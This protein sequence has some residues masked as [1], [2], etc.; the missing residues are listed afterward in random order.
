MDKIP[1]SIYD[2]FGYL[3]PGAL[4]L[5]SIDYFLL[6]QQLIK[7]AA[8]NLI[9]GF[10]SLILVYI[11]GHIISSVSCWCFEKIFVKKFLKPPSVT[12]FKDKRSIVKLKKL[13]STYY[14]P[15]S[16]N[17]QDN[18]IKKLGIESETSEDEKYNAMFQ[19]AFSR[20][21]IHEPS[22]L[23]LNNFLY[24]Y[25]FARSVSL[26]CLVMVLILFVSSVFYKISICPWWIVGFIFAF[27]M[28]FFRYLKF[29][30][31]YDRD[32]FLSYLSLPEKEAGK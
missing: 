26:V 11:I 5:I 18:I 15:L 9:T 32:M 3:T 31:Y 2:F 30:R 6:K 28:M 10:V 24:L 22:M 1:F 7:S 4:F 14:N 16:K 27:I 17:V 8:E 25:G 13:F 21:K 20:V 29:Y 19:L 23:S 12:L